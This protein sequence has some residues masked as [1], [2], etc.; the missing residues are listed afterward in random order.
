MKKLLSVVKKILPYWFFIS[1]V[2]VFLVFLF[3][4]YTYIIFIAN[5]ATPERLMNSNNT[6]LVLTDRN[7]KVFYKSGQ[8]KE[9]EP[10]P[11]NE[12][13]LLL[14]QATIQIEDREFYDHPGFSFTGIARSILLNLKVQ[15]LTYGGST[16]TQQLV[17]N[18]L[19]TADK[20]IRRKFQELILSFEV[21]RRYDKDKILEMYLNSIY[22]GEG[23]YGVAAA[24]ETYFGKN[25]NEVNLSEAVILAALPQA[26]SRLSPITGD[27]QQL[28]ERQKL[29][30]DR[31]L[32]AKIIENEEYREAVGSPPDF[33][34]NQPEE[35][36]TAPHFA[37][38]VKSLLIDMYGED[39]VIRNGFQVTTSLD[40]SLQEEAQNILSGH[41]DRLAPQNVENGGLVVIKPST[42]EILAMVG[43]YDW[44]N[45]TFGKFNVVFSKRQ[46]GS[47][48][49]PVVYTKAFM[50]GFKTTDILHD[51]PTDFG[52]YSPKNYDNRFRGD[53]TLRR[54]LANSLNIP[55]VELLSMIG[56]DAA[57]SL[58]GD[59][60]IT[61]LT[62]A[63]RYGLSL[64]LGGGEVELF[65]LTRAYGIFS[66]MGNSVPSHFFLE[67]KDKFGNLIY[68]YNPQTLIEDKIF[69]N[70]ELS[71]YESVMKEKNINGSGSKRII[72]E[73]Y[74]YLTT[75]ILSDSFARA[76]IFGSVSALNLSRQAA[77]KT[78]TTDDYRDAWTIG[79]TPDLVTGVWIGNND[80]RPMSRVAGSVGAA[81]IWHD[82]MEA[83]HR[84]LPQNNFSEPSGII[85]LA[86]CRETL[87][88][89]CDCADKIE[90][91]FDEDTVSAVDCP[92]PTPESED[93]NIPEENNDDNEDE[94]EEEENDP[95]LTPVP[96][97]TVDPSATPELL[98]T[99][100][101][102]L[103]TGLLPTL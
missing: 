71:D 4:L 10:V 26:P 36:F 33:L 23:A 68:A 50:E 24:A 95:T 83:A 16:I 72:R 90:E 85:R 75:D 8:L 42:G 37:V 53:V 39:T 103:P 100:E 81:P 59:L 11:L 87:L 94:P 84:R 47:A 70:S 64:T 76:E 52:N 67:I 98:P 14:R 61:S 78:G 2:V 25:I 96:T 62:E 6:G 82:V 80:N 89:G 45:E 99:E 51:R 93:E 27:R 48:F 92:T 66:Q 28:F 20:T 91:V 9:L 15:D 32:E 102:P 97:P 35:T 12:T 21:E 79:Y 40:L 3:G 58:A 19:L 30:L 44:N 88:P 18:S 60:G 7:G 86:V 22:Y 38:Y 49:K 34:E 41:V 57:L 5:L 13:P 63:E 77:V 56:V 31:L 74:A 46:P 73:K 43:S 29:I 101:V 17:K 54:A 1:V 69:T 65:E 55:A